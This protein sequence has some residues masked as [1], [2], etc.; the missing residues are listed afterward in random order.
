MTSKLCYE[1]IISSLKCE[2]G[3]RTISRRRY[4][5][6]NTKQYSI[7]RQRCY[8]AFVLSFIATAYSLAPSNYRTR[9]F[10]SPYSFSAL[11][12]RSKTAVMEVQK[13]KPGKLPFDD[14]LNERD[15]TG[16]STVSLID[17]SMLEMLLDKSM[18]P[19]ETT[20]ETKQHKKNGNSKRRARMVPGAMG[21][22]TLLKHYNEQ[23]EE[24]NKMNSMY[25]PSEVAS[26][27]SSTTTPPKRPRGRPRKTVQSELERTASTTLQKGQAK[28]E[29]VNGISTLTAPP[30][31]ANPKQSSVTSDVKTYYKTVLLT[32]KEE[33]YLGTQVE[34]MVKCEN[35]HEGLALRLDRFP[36]MLEWA[37]AC[38]F[39]DT[40]KDFFER[41]AYDELRPAGFEAMFSEKDPDMFVGNGLAS[42]LGV[43]RGRGRAKKTPPGQLEAFYDDTENRFRPPGSPKIPKVKISTG[44]PTDFVNKLMDSKTAKQRMVSSN[45]RLVL[46][47]SRKYA[48]VGV[49][50]QDLVQ[51]GSLGLS[52]AAEKFEPKKGFKFSTYASWWIQ[53][54]VFRSLAYHSRTIRLPVHVHNL[55]NRIRKIRRSLEQELARS[56]TNEEMAA[57]LQMPV[58][59]YNKMMR[60]TRRSISLE[61]PKYKQ[62]PKD[63]GHESDDVLRDTISAAQVLPDETTPEKGVDRSLFHE[64][65]KDMLKILEEDERR[66]IYARYGLDDGLGKTVTTVAAQMNMSKSWVRSQECR[67]LRKLRRPWYEK[68]LKEHEDSLTC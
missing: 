10:I 62:N 39:N 58:A 46:S 21:Y 36:T 44:T 50:L 54:T 31:K 19:P 64:D 61:I 25:K 32:A 13:V 12:A 65:L 6:Q 28:E 63:F 9:A 18:N 35:V 17:E 45:M 60:L 42:E 2:V 8:A 11:K 3:S 47:I 20:P 34:F 16:E 56:P 15:L 4:A 22:R 67:A 66:V 24:E 43:G 29:L 5:R 38:G 57:E 59:K 52:R 53:Q 30:Q 1:Q 7:P 26:P 41:K 55:L 51:E 33:Y 40:D 37:H 68:R 49:S 27:S 48:N 14:M 23:E